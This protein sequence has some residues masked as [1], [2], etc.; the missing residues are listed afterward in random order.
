MTNIK[1]CGLSRPQ[2]IQAANRLKPDFIGFVFAPKSK[3]YVSPQK[4]EELKAL[5]DPGIRAVGV[6][7]NEPLET[8]AQLLDRGVIDLAQLHGGE[9]EDYVRALKSRTGKP[10]I[11]AFRVAT[12]ED[13]R[14]AEESCADCI[15]LDSGAGTGTVFDWDLLRAA[16]RP[17]FLAGGWG[18]TTWPGR[19]SSFIPMGWM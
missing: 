1:L 3:R 18:R 12:A 5:L 17:Y 14:Q 2:D 11:R 19:W 10:V 16:R 8:V 9:D 6:F 7:V 15:L 4:A 13:V